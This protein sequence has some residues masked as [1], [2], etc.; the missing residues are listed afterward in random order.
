M[1]DAEIGGTASM[2]SPHAAHHIESLSTALKVQVKFE[3]AAPHPSS[4][5]QASTMG[6]PARR[7]RLSGERLKAIPKHRLVES[8]EDYAEVLNE[9][10]IKPGHHDEIVTGILYKLR[11]KRMKK[12]A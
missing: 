1:S 7:D 3:Y 9:L 12:Y 8:G 4:P 2:P 6:A 11:S 10:Q 5:S